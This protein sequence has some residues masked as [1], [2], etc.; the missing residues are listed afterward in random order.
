VRRFGIDAFPLIE[1]AIQEAGLRAL[2]RWTGEPRDQQ[3]EGWLLRVA[4]NAAIDALRRE[5]RSVPLAPED[6]G[7][8]TPPAPNLDDELRLVFLCCHPVLPRAA[9]ISL[10]LRVAFGFSTTQI[11]RA[12]LSDERTVA[13]R[14]VRA[15]QRLRDEGRRIE[16][17][18]PDE[19]PSRLRPT[20][21]VLYQLFTEGHATTSSEAGVD[22]TLCNESLRLAR[23][24]TDDERWTSPEA[25]A[26]RA[27]FGFHA[28]RTA[29]RIAADGSLLLLH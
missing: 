9:Q 15:K 8:A 26:L 4:H 24:L 3:L 14:I 16:L 23:L 20:L 5:R 6:L 12:F 27:L 29:A 2:E 19:L 22:D 17:P 1:T 13:Q 21:D 18:D 28:G 25:E 7:E 10:T 11:A